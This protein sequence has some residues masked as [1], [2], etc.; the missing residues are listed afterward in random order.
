MR[1]LALLKRGLRFSRES[2]AAADNV[3]RLYNA[4][5]G[6]EVH[7]IGTMHISQR[8]AD[9]VQQLIRSVRPNVVAVELCPSRMDCLLEPDGGDDGPRRG[10]IREFLDC[11]GTFGERLLHV[12]LHFYY[13]GVRDAGIA[14]ASEFVVAGTEAMKLGAEIHL[15]DENSKVTKERLNRALTMPVAF[16]LIRKLWTMKECQVML[17]AIQNR[18]LSFLESMNT[19]EI[20]SS[21]IRDLRLEFPEV[22]DAV[23]DQ[24]DEIMTKRLLCCDGKIVAVVGL[25]HMD[26]I[27]ERWN[28]Y[29]GKEEHL[30]AVRDDGS[31]FT[32]VVTL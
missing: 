13:Q 16:R 23:V 25:A 19:R 30:Q 11:P 4:A 9:K 2:F 12:V 26:G 21:L 18:N 22:V 24:R 31:L 10:V 7:L 29:Q 1:S 8:S 32:T 6:A 17:H 15:I 20:A 5:N 3:A 28:A 14:T 27:E